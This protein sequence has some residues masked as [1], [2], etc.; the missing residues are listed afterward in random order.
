MTYLQQFLW[1]LLAIGP[2]IIFHEFGHYLVAR[3]CDVKVLRFSVGFG[4]VLWSRKLGRDQTEWAISAIPLGGYV[5]MLD[6]RDPDTASKAD[7]DHA[8]EFTSQHVWKRIAII[9][10]GPI[11][12]FILAAMLF[13]GI[14]MYGV[15]DI[16]TRLRFLPEASAAHQAG[17]READLVTSVNGDAVA[18][19]SELRFAV[20][21]AAMDKEPLELELEQR[22]GVRRTVNLDVAA[23]EGISLDKDVVGQ[24][25]LLPYQGPAVLS[26][27]FDGA[28]KRAGLQAGDRVTA[29]DGTPVRD[30]IELIQ[31][32]H[33]AG[34]K[35]VQLTVLRG[36]ATFQASVT[37]ER[38]ATSGAP[39]IRVK[40][41]SGGERVVVSSDPLTA[42]GQGVSATWN[43]AAMQLKMIGKIFTGSVSWKNV[44]GPITMADY[45]EQTAKAGIIV[46]LGFMAVISVSLGVM[47]LLPI[48]VLDGG[49]LLYYSVEVLT[50]RP[51]PEHV[52][53]TMRRLGVIML[54]MLMMLAIFNDIARRL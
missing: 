53:D 41:L 51:L 38:D 47:N 19:W 33:G 52:D 50:G 27:V 25:G 8:R 23:Y 35:T 54:V 6:N 31:V 42:L 15:E 45:A 26:E 4:K 7:A 14:S 36:A 48:P 24:L 46:F 29:I 18:S 39:V 20:L 10:A 49:L 16:S 21:D 2:L 13:A 5:K 30:R 37:P 9:A 17:V 1:F 32:L 3:L 12:N 43:Q 40:L 22:D 28:A 34:V 44:T 11:A